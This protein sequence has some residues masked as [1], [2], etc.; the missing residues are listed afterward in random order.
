[1]SAAPGDHGQS[2][3]HMQSKPHVQHLGLGAHFLMC[4]FNYLPWQHLA[5]K[6]ISFVWVVSSEILVSVLLFD[7]LF[8]GY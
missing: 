3:T 4:I 7:S 6:L 5:A 8:L 1:V 2:Q